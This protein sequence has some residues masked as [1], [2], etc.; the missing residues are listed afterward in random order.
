MKLFSS[1]RIRL[2]A[3]MLLAVFLA[4]GIWL[5]CQLDQMSRQQTGWWDASMRTAA[6]QILLSL[7]SNQEQLSGEPGFKLP[8]HAGFQGDKVSFQV[9]GGRPMRIIMASPS[10]PS[11]PLKPDF[12]DGFME[13]L[14]GD[15]VWRV[16][17]LSDASGKVQIQVGRP[18]SQL[19]AELKRWTRASLVTALAIFAGLGAMA[20]LVIRWSLQPVARLQGAIAKRSAQEL[21]PLPTSNL[22][23]EV[24]PLV[25]SF[26]TML[27]RVRG[28]METERRFIADAAHELRTPLAAMLMHAQI[29][30][31]SANG[32]DIVSAR[33]ALDV[34]AGVAQR[35]AR[36][37]EQLLDSARLQSDK[38]SAL[39]PQRIELSDLLP[40]VVMD[41]ERTAKLKQQQIS[42]EIEPCEVSGRTDEIGILVR[43]LL[44][45]AIRYTPRHGR[46]VVSCK[47]IT[48]HGVPA[49]RL[50]VSDNGPG[51]P[52]EERSLIFERFYRAA[53]NQ[54][55]G[56]GIG[57][58]LV[59]R[60]AASH[61]ARIQTGTGLAGR[62][63]EIAVLFS[64]AA[65]TQ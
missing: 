57:L 46:I 27:E 7:P 48:S 13:G 60:I 35:S 9:W 24:Q 1:L 4:W 33:N 30:Q 38:L 37:A 54:D 29:A 41:F 11:L 64:G 56:S 8:P 45:N 3:V 47:N 17:A 55:G 61:R 18:L 15:E 16:Y 36:L 23:V 39:P 2:L 58:S 42:L 5:Y 25:L 6:S 51:V 59:S 43:N 40:V 10:A 26:N 49:V 62:G 12:V 63:L 52:A 31:Q 28:A 20:W 22:P 53:G 44:D 21:D 65:S 34:L 14:I 32:G 50:S 19:H